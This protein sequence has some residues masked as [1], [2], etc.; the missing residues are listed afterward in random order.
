MLVAKAIVKIVKAQIPVLA[1]LSH[2]CMIED[3][4]G[5]LVCCLAPPKLKVK[6]SC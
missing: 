4:K 3:T 5:L 2:L 6:L 1:T